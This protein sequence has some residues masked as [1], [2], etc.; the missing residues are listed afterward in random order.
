MPLAELGKLMLLQV[1][2]KTLYEILMLP[3]TIRVVRFVKHRE[4]TDVYDDDI[5][6]NPLKI[7]DL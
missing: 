1:I 6:Y 3:I 7:F 5:S 4:G 2:V